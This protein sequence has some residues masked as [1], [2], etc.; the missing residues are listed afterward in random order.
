MK[1][2]H[3]TDIYSLTPSIPKYKAPLNYAGQQLITLTMICTYN[4]FTK[5]VQTYMK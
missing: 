1:S 4:M 5:L 3:L 2:L